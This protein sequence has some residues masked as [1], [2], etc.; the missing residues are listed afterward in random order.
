MNL[1]PNAFD[2]WVYHRTK[3]GDRYLVLRTSKQ[4]ADK[5][6]HGGCFW[7]IPSDFVAKGE[8][9]VDAVRR[10]LWRFRLEPISVYAAEHSYTFFNSR[11]NDVILATV[12]AAEVASET[13]I[14]LGWEHSAYAWV[15]ASRASQRV[16]FRGLKEG[17][18]W[19][20]KY[21]TETS[22]P[23]RQLQLL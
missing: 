7:Q 6:F 13:E 17:L 8:T 18:R 3:R 1:R 21:V 20:R 14:P 19:V 12:F 4:K 11:Y 16:H 9:I 2:V 23:A 15:S 22:R 5:W 10:E